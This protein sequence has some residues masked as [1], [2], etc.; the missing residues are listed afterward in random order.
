MP[1][2]M[3]ASP[4]PG[5]V[6]TAYMKSVMQTMASLGRAGIYAEFETFDSIGD[7]VIARNTLATRFLLKKDL[8]HLFMVD[9][10]M[11]WQSDLCE[12]LLACYKPVVGTGYAKRQFHA[13]RIDR[14]IQSGCTG[15]EAILIATDWVSVFDGGLQQIKL[16]HG[17]VRVARHGFGAVLIE[18][19]V[20]EK[21]VANQSAPPQRPSQP[22]AQPE[23]YNFFTPRPA[24]VAQQVSEDASF[25]ERWVKD[26]GGDLWIYADA[27]I[28]HIGDF[29]FGGQF[30]EYL[31][32]MQKVTSPKT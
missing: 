29:A 27:V 20:L 14:A 22:G 31:Q 17:L 32:A 7:L 5:E 30:V 11:M 23:F 3:I 25:C 21:M 6:K 10:D 19:A 1:R 12:R 18:R 15:A 9:A 8:T 13:D 24:K 26:C 16:E 2:V 4:T 28:Y